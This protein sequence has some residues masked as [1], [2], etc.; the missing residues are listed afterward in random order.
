[1]SLLALACGGTSP[2]SA[3][4]DAG[5]TENDVLF[6][7]AHPASDARATS[8]ASATTSDS[9]ASTNSANDA[10]TS[11]SSTCIGSDLMN[12]LGKKRM[13]VGATMADASASAAPWDF[14]YLYIAGGLMDSSDVCSTCASS[15]T[16]NGVTCASSG[17]GCAWWGCWQWD[18]QAPGQYARDFVSKAKAGGQIPMITYDVLLEASGVAE[19]TAEATQAARN[20]SFMTRYFA[21]FRLLLQA[22][23]SS[24]AFL[25]VEPDFWGY[26]EQAS[27][28]AHAQ[29]AVAT[30]NPTDCAS[31][32]NS[33]AGMGQ[34]MIA[35]ARKYAPNA[36]VGLHA[37]SWSTGVEVAYNTQSSLDVAAEAKKTAAFLTACGAGASDFIVVEASDR[38]AG[39]YD[40]IG[41]PHWW[42]ATNTTLPTFHQDFAWLKALAEAANKPLFEWQIPIGNM[43][44]PNTTSAWHDNR[45]DY[46]FA[47]MNELAAAHVFAVAYGAGASGMTT[48]ESDGGHLTSMDQAYVSSGG[49][50]LCP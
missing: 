34:C 30:A 45:V 40:T 35:M 18:Q 20:V 39:Y 2:P 1:M 9:D 8:D 11:A 36:L 6:A 21:D 33:I 29:A 50:A 22:L 37:S 5:S 15:C 24:V 26:A 43:S 14:R 7:D 42:D 16:S 32:E 31:Q 13:L 27:P 46:F 17:P 4:E 44:L 41:K 28:D 49:Q 38:D 48:P 19:G 47:H 3:D 12:K 25:H 10:S 23:G